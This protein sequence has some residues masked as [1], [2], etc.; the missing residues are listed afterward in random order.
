MLVPCCWPH[1]DW[2]MYQCCSVIWK[3]KA[4]RSAFCVISGFCSKV[5]DNSDFVGYFAA[6]T[7]DSLL[8]FR[9]KL[10]VQSARVKNW[11]WDQ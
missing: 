4:E 9:E 11:R 1:V 6:S 10:L 2:H 3:F 7:G 5:D 8:K